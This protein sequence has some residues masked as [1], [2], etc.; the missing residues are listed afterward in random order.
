MTARVLP[1]H[2]VALV[3]RLR[4]FGDA[5]ALTWAGRSGMQ[6]LS[7]AGLAA[8]VDV[9]RSAL[10]TT[11]RLVVLEAGNDVESVVTLLAA[12]TGGHPVVL[13]AP[14][15]SAGLVEAWDPDV[16]ACGAEIESR[17]EGSAHAL[18]PDLA[19]MLSTSG[20]TGS[21]KLVRLSTANLD[22]NAGQIADALGLRP[23][24]VAAT[25]LPL[26]YCYG[27]SVLLSALSVGAGVLLT[28]L[29]VVDTCFWSAF[30]ESGGSILAGVPYTFDLL[31]AAG[32]A[33]MS[34]PRLRLL[35]QAGGRMD[36]A[37][38]R[39]WVALGEERGFDLL[40]MYG[41]TEATARMATLPTHLAADHPSSIG[42]AVRGGRF[43]LASVEGAP[44]G[45]GELVFEGGNVMMGYASSAADLA[46][47]AEVSSLHTGDLARFTADGL[48]E[49]V[50]RRSRFAKVCGLRIDLD[51]VE[52][53]LTRGG[54]TAYVM[55]GGDRLLVAVTEDSGRVDVAAVRREVGERYAVPRAAV[56]VTDVGE[57]PRTASGKVDRPALAALVDAFGEGTCPTP[58][59]LLARSGED[60]AGAP[61]LDGART[62]KGSEAVRALYAE[63]LDRP[64]AT[65]DDSFVT[66]RGD[67]L[68]YVE[69]SVRLEGLL[70]TLPESWHVRPVRELAAEV[71]PVEEATSR[72]T[73]AAA[74]GRWGRFGRWGRWR[75]LETSVLLRGVAIAVIV[76]THAG[77][78]DVRGGAHVLLAVA[79]FAFARFQLSASA[80][81]ERVAHA[82]ESATRIAVPAMVWLG[83]LFLVDERYSPWNPVLLTSIGGS[84]VHPQWRYWFVEAVVH[85]LVG[86]TALLAVPTLDRLERARPF[87]VPLGLALVAL[88]FRYGVID[89][90]S[91]HVNGRPAV[92]LWLFALGWAMA[93]TRVTWHRWLLTAYVL[94]VVPGFFSDPVRDAT[95]AG[96]LLVLLWVRSVR[97]PAFVVPVVVP[98]ASASLF[99]YLVQ[100]EVMGRVG[101][102][103][104]GAAVAILTGWIAWRGASPVIEPVARR[105]G[106]AATRVL[107]RSGSTLS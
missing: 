29:S 50:G 10:G 20:S 102:S 5:V 32:F 42:V 57:V 66:L 3:G 16:V 12:L 61:A 96:G 36:P 74:K 68:S 40:V 76:L 4:S 9:R 79:G 43:S 95:L 90:G 56:V 75:S 99:I 31:D 64:D 52:A 58:G 35:T 65:L 59:R 70:G 84:N 88:L 67:S 93:R 89:V 33:S 94:V 48:V 91:H 55:D 15:G 18:H 34:L 45:V 92:V 104:L 60:S 87:A 107:T 22:C 13:A 7:Y 51:R 103:P 46:R 82:L 100:W 63:L 71:G 47:G 39:R 30:E 80:R 105:V 97:V 11:P 8:R 44:V 78:L 1:Q 62:D 77:V 37:A 106:A 98:V 25:T 21:P 73:G 26:Q 24:D 85:I 2:R 72:S 6:T 49:I 101:Y 83:V 69:A 53:D 81:T 27:L 23:D 28:D 17:R 38:V 54:R 86:V 14:G 41:Q 19:L